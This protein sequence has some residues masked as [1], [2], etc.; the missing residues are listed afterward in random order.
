MQGDGLI[1]VPN[2]SEAFLAERNFRAPGSAITVTLEGTRPLLVELQALTSPS[3]FSNPRRTPNGVDANRLLLISAVL[4]RRAGLRL[5]E[6]DLFVNVVGGLKIS[7]PAADLALAA[8]LAS[9][10]HEA[11][12]PADLAL[13]GELGLGGELRTVSRPAARLREAAKL[14]FRR[15]LLPRLRRPLPD[16]PP[17]L[18]LLPVRDL[19]AALKLALPGARDAV[20]SG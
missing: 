6:Q 1:E 5:Q 17:E 9:S 3:V 7:E 13:L 8:A 15:V 11:P 20:Q 2:P 10:Y 12:L 14:G 19:A 18:E 4:M 16:L